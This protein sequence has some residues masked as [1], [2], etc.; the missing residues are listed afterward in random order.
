MPTGVAGAD[1]A[2]IK[3]LKVS[4]VRQ[5]A[6]KFEAAQD[7]KLAEVRAVLAAAEPYVPED[8]RKPGRFAL[9]RRGTRGPL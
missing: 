6:A 3:V 4:Q 1:D 5:V 9:R 8:E 7:I 2:R